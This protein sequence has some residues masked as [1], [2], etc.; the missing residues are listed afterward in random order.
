MSCYPSCYRT[1]RIMNAKKK[2]LVH[3]DYNDEDENVNF[4]VK[5][6]FRKNYIFHLDPWEEYPFGRR[7]RSWKETTKKK[8]SWENGKLKHRDFVLNEIL[9]FESKSRNVFYDGDWY[10][11]CRSIQ[12]YKNLADRLGKNL[13]VPHEVVDPTKISQENSDEEDWC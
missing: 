10:W 12:K 7:G 2:D 5:K 1:P 9:D 13:H 4:L 3:L 8:H 11:G 6:S